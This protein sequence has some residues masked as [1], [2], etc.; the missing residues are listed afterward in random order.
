M[1]AGGAF[2]VGPINKRMKLLSGQREF[3]RENPVRSHMACR[4]VVCM[5]FV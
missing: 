3:K 4:T 1:G 2:D 5:E